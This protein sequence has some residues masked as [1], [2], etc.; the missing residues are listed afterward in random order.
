MQPRP[1]AASRARACS[2]RLH[3][4]F[5]TAAALALRISTTAIKFSIFPF[6]TTTAENRDSL[7]FCARVSA[8]AIFHRKRR[9]RARSPHDNE[10]LIRIP[11]L[12]IASAPSSF[13]FFGYLREDYRVIRRAII[14]QPFPF[15]TDDARA[16][17]MRRHEKIPP[18]HSINRIGMY[19]HAGRRCNGGLNPLFHRLEKMDLPE[20]RVDD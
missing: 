14:Y 18:R 16:R 1:T 5:N 9:M 8:L 2:F 20:P 19:P 11:A 15:P 6:I 3:I 13:F 17:H 10:L 7:F 12:Y 4:Y